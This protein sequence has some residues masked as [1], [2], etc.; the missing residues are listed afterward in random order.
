[1][2]REHSTAGAATKC[3]TVRDNGIYNT[4][5][6]I[7]IYIYI[8]IYPDDN[9]FIIYKIRTHNYYMYIIHI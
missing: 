5:P 4:I 3:S 6:Y 9:Y 1:M 7:Y 2:A 8:H